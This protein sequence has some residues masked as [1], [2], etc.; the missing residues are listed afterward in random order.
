VIEFG[1]LCA[2][3]EGASLA[4][5]ETLLPPAVLTTLSELFRA[6]LTEQLACVKG[7]LQCTE[8]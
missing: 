1:T 4:L 2:L 6:T 3:P 5:T 7:N 8:L